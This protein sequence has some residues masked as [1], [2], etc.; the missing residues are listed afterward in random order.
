M[1]NSI[2]TALYNVVWAFLLS[3]CISTK[4]PQK[5]CLNEAYMIYVYANDHKGSHT[6]NEIQATYKDSLYQVYYDLNLNRQY[7]NTTKGK[8]Y[9]KKQ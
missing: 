6:E 1:H 5:E 7:I 3:G 8:I 4:T 2:C 9:L